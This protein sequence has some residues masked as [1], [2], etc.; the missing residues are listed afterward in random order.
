MKQL[1]ILFLALTGLIT[2]TCA[3]TVQGLV[4]DKTTGEPL[5]G[6]TI[7]LKG[8]H[9][10]TTSGLNGKFSIKQTPE[11]T[12][13]LTVFYV[14]YKNYDSTICLSPNG[15]FLVIFL[16]QKK[17]EMSQVIVSGKH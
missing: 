17:I 15:S 2:T 3:Q 11:G 16:E 9:G 5:P 4:V 8:A 12:Y 13:P 14:G 7:V 6:A 10:H 1:L